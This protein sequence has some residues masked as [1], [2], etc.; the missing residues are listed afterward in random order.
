MHTIRQRIRLIMFLSLASI[1]ILGAFSF[2][3]F[4]QQN[5][6]TDKTQQY[7]EA[8]VSS[9]YIKDD[10][11]DTIEKQETYLAQPSASNEET[12]LGAIAS[13]HKS[14]ATYEEKY[15][16]TKELREYFAQIKESAATYE[17]ELEKVTSMNETIGYTSDEGLRKI[18]QDASDSFHSIA[19]N[20]GD[21]VSS[22]LEDVLQT[23]RDIIQPPNGAVPNKKAFDEAVS[24]FKSAIS[25]ANLDSDA[26]SAINS[27]LLKYRSAMSTLADTRTQAAELAANFETAALEVT[28]TVDSV[29]QTAVEQMNEMKEANQQTS[30]ILGIIL[31]TVIALSFLLVLCI[32]WPLIRAISKSISQLKEAAEIIGDGNLAY[33]VPITTKDE[34][35]DVGKTFN[36]MAAKMEHSMVKVKDASEIMDESSSYLAAASQQTAAQYEEVNQ[37][38]GQVAGGAQDQ[39]AQLEESGTLLE[40][41]RYSIQM[42]RSETAHVETAMKQAELEGSHGLEQ[43]QQL[44]TTSAS[45]LTLAQT[46]TTEIQQAVKQADQIRSIVKTIEEISESTNLLALNAAIESARAG[47]HGKGFAVVADEVKKLAERS[48]QEA[49]QIHKLVGSMNQQMTDLAEEAK[50]FDAFQQV[51]AASVEETRS[52][53]DRIHRQLQ[54]GSTKV[55][56]ITSSVSD[57]AA[58][59][60]A[61]ADML[62]HINQISE[63]AASTAEEVAASSDTQAASIDMLTNAA[64]Q[65]QQLAKDLA[66]EVSQF[67]FAAVPSADSEDESFAEE[68][69]QEDTSIEAA[70]SYKKKHAE[71]AKEEDMKKTS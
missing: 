19:S 21:D 6:M 35:A 44:H 3:Y 38:I 13:V 69:E 71:Q 41:V 42:M 10:M 64:S 24:A 1:L 9:Q 50:A 7:Q 11:L 53:F 65:L 5:N 14:A 25:E 36:Q 27:S 49:Q 18:I 31:L 22:N 46:L 63:E 37:A 56:D 28:T 55:K 4:Y 39:A 2:Y 26:L 12:V 34:M 57:V 60:E 68:K 23:E 59:N 54:E 62:G 32:G 17:R 29:G 30:T 67:E 70:P 66:T 58:N 16:D 47:E 52:A 43:M 15:K 20:S 33:R 40:K 8:Y 51:Q 45:F 61:V 48:K